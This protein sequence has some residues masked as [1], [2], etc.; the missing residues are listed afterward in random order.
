MALYSYFS[1]AMRKYKSATLFRLAMDRVRLSVLIPTLN[2]EASIGKTIS[3]IPRS[4]DMEIAII[5]GLSTD[6]TRE[7]AESLG[8]RVIMERRKGYGGATSSSRWTATRPTPPR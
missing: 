1:D 7:I 6:R 5:D 3:Q 4:P 2:E 8:A